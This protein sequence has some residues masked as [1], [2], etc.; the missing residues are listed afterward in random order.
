MVSGCKVI[1]SESEIRIL[2][3]NEWMFLYCGGKYPEEE[4]LD[5]MVVTGLI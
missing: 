4:F 3:I 5:H 2:Q 1:G